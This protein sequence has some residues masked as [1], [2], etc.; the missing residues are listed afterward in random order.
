MT[1]QERVAGIRRM[2]RRD[3]LAAYIIP[4]TDPHLS[5][6]VPEY[7][8]RRKWVSGFTGSAGDVVITLKEAG[9]WT[10]GRYFLQA[11]DELDSDVFTLFKMY[12]PGTPTIE[13]FLADSLHKGKLVGVDAQTLSLKRADELE[14]YLNP[15]GLKLKFIARNYVDAIWPDRPVFPAEMI[16]RHSD[17][18][19]G[20]TVKAKLKELRGSMEKLGA[21]SHVIC[22]L[23]SIA[24]LYN[25][26]G[27]DVDYNPVAISYAIV[28]KRGAMFFIDEDKIEPKERKWI[29][30]FAK[31][32]PYKEFK[33]ALRDLAKSKK[34]VLIDADS[35]T[36]WVV[37]QLKGAPV[38]FADSPIVAAKAK[39]NARQIGG[40]RDALRRDGVAM[41][42]F[43]H[44]FEN[45]LPGSRM[46]EVD[47]ADKL[48]EFRAMGKRFKGISFS[49]I[50]G[51]AGNGAIMHYNPNL[52][53]G[54]RIRKRGTLLID[55]GGQYLD[56]T[57][58]I[59]R[60]II[61]GEPTKRE[62]RFFTRV[63]QGHM[64]LQQVVFPSGVAG[65][66]LE[67]LAR[68][69]LW[70]ER[71]DYNHGTGHGVGHYLCVH[72]G[73]M[74]FSTRNSGTMTE[75]NILTNEPGY[76][77][78]GKFG[79]RIENQVVV[80]PERD[81]AK[82]ERVWYKLEDMTLCPIDLNLVEPELMTEDEVAWLNAYHKRVRREL[83][84]Y[85]DASEKRWLREATQA[86]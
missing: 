29:R 12:M 25:I 47:L 21:E 10:D 33:K 23:D 72:E 45:A 35:T 37:E 11:A 28:N 67:L 80:V 14:K 77:E 48:T 1:P 31:I 66:R 84:P 2:M 60:T 61:I 8:C 78:P 32:R 75:G 55:S 42:R 22:A 57:T 15:R 16:E 68:L 63:L 40:M 73:P 82:D 85:L 56:G 4:S 30:T 26:R 20:A 27:G 24:W 19:A 6:Y 76:Y 36:R 86:I 54:V 38:I 64:A 50:V 3:G 9:L 43:F 62:K 69:P 71:H 17:R 53:G 74:G 79:I 70:D 44:W 51:F 41:V 5:E 46:T 18:F 59:T 7:W 13:E 65:G 39:K 83:L 81:F 52:S 49:S 58:D 34:K